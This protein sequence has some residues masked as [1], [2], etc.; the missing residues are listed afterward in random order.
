MAG[1]PARAAHHPA[2]LFAASC[3]P[4]FTASGAPARPTNMKARSAAQAGLMKFAEA[5]WAG[6]DGS[7]GHRRHAAR[8]RLART[9]RERSRV[10]GVASRLGGARSLR[11][12]LPACGK[13]ASSPTFSRACRRSSCAAPSCRAGRRSPTRNCSARRSGAMPKSYGAR[14]VQGDVGAL[15]AGER[16]RGCDPAEARPHVPGAQSRSSPP[17]P[18]RISWHGSSATASRSRPSA[19]T[20]RRCR[21]APST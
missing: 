1:R 4:G 5:E 2:G 12:R 16:W 19:A 17:A 9:L 7:L 13:A 11:H 21:S 6:A 14:F 20:T 15:Q 3:C 10:P 18:G 8:G